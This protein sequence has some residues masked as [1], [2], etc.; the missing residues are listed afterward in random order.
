MANTKSAQ[1]KTR[2]TERRRLVNKF[3]VTRARTNEKKIRALVDGG[4]KEGAKKLYSQFAS[5]ID[6]ASKRGSMH[7]NTAARKKSR[8]AVLLK[9]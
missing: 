9:D 2:V 3:L 6:K 7:K 5:S 1:K 8:I 4:D